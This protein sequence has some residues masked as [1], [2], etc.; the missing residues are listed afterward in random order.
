MEIPLQRGE[1]KNIRAVAILTPV[2]RPDIFVDA[3]A[4]DQ[5]LLMIFGG[6]AI[7]PQLMLQAAMIDARKEDSRIFNEL[8]FDMH[9][10]RMLRDNLFTKLKRQAPF[11][12]I[13]PEVVE[14]N[15]TVYKLQDKQDKA[16][17]D[18]QTIAKQLG[19]DT[20]VEL[21]V[22][23]CGIKDP[24][25]FAKPHTLL[26]TKVVVSRARDKKVLWQTKLGQAIPQ[27]K[28]FG[29]DYEKYEVED[30]KLLK[31][32]LDTVSSILAEQIVEALGFKAQIPTAKLLKTARP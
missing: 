2:S 26:V 11:Y 32:E 27:E 29:F 25:V 31:E 28:K 22:L 9:V 21:Y 17:E 1:M 14:D 3:M 13:P 20:I 4:D 10:G 16:L 18:Y 12:V 23:S 30:A 19:A 6:P 7:L 15:I 24:G 8:T 5:L